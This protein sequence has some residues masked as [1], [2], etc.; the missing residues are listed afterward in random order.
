MTETSKKTNERSIKKPL[1][2]I[3]G[4]TGRKIYGMQDVRPERKRPSKSRLTEC[5]AI[6]GTRCEKR[7]PSGWD[8]HK[9]GNKHSP[10]ETLRGRAYD[11]QRFRDFKHPERTAELLGVSVSFVKKWTRIG[12]AAADSGKSTRNAFR[13]LPTVRISAPKGPSAEQIRIVIDI[14]RGNPL[15]GSKKIA[16]KMPDGIRLSEYAV[17]NV[18]REYDLIIPRGKYHRRK[19]VRFESPFPMHTIQLDFKTWENGTHSIWALDDHSRAI[20]GYRVAEKATTDVVIDLMEEVIGKYGVPIRVLTDHGCQFTTMHE[21]GTHGFDEWLDERKITHMM[22]SVAHPQT[23]GKIERS[24]GTAIIEASYFGPTETSDEWNLT[25]GLWIE[26]YN[27]RRP[28]MSLDYEFPLDVF[29][30]DRIERDSEEWLKA[31][32]D[33]W[34]TAYA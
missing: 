34:V 4:K 27:N 20:L 17:A 11:D 32:K 10:A 14:R 18:L 26:Y 2:R 5:D 13:A 16:V 15:L 33:P 19:Y 22:G 3:H 12:R 25:I 7:E 21:H 23:Q 1:F 31:T 28:H 9:I 30:K 29:K 6:L 8:L 24:H